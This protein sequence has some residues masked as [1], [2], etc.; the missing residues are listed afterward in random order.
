MLKVYARYKKP[1][2]LI[3]NVIKE[4][5]SSKYGIKALDFIFR[6]NSDAK[7]SDTIIL[8]AMRSP[9]SSILIT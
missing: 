7:I 6:Y 1:L 8:E 9:Y 3:E 2:A 4:V 5:A